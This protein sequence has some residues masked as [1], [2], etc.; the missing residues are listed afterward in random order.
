V[1]LTDDN[2]INQAAL[3]MLA[4]LP[5]EAVTKFASDFKVHLRSA[6]HPIVS[7]NSDNEDYDP[8]ED[9]AYAKA[10]EEKEAQWGIYARARDW[11]IANWPTNKIRI[12]TQFPDLIE[13][14]LVDIMKEVRQ[15][16]AKRATGL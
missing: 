1:I 4:G 6:K 8:N 12:S 3:N 15:E 11:A 10:L 2:E 9:P 7:S 16:M 5:E 14:E 13:Y